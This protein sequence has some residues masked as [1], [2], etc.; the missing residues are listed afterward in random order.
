M[1]RKQTAT[2]KPKGLCPNMT[3]YLLGTFALAILAC[4]QSKDPD[5]ENFLSESSEPS[6]NTPFAPD[7]DH[8]PSE[9]AYAL[10]ETLQSLLR[11]QHQEP[12][13]PPS[14]VRL[15][16][17][18]I[19]AHIG[20]RCAQIQRD[21]ALDPGTFDSTSWLTLIDFLYRPAPATT[22]GRL[23]TAREA[24][25]R[26]LRHAVG[27]ADHRQSA[28]ELL[29]LLN[30][31]TAASHD[32]RERQRIRLQ[33]QGASSPH[34]Q[35]LQDALLAAEIL[36]AL[37][38]LATLPPNEKPEAFIEASLSS[39]PLAA[40]S[41]Q[42]NEDA[43]Q[44][45]RI[46]T[47]HCPT[48]CQ[49]DGA[50]GPVAQMPAPMPSPACPEQ[51]SLDPTISIANALVLLG[52]QHLQRFPAA[53]SGGRFPLLDNTWQNCLQQLSIPALLPLDASGRLWPGAPLIPSSPGKL[54]PVDPVHWLVT[55]THQNLT[56]RPWPHFTLGHTSVHTP[57]SLTLPAP[58]QWQ[59]QST[60]WQH[61][62]GQLLALLNAE[63][64]A[65]RTP[66]TLAI[67]AE[68][69][70]PYDALH[71]ALALLSEAGFESAA[72]LVDS[73]SPHG[74]APFVQPRAATLSLASPPPHTS[75]L[76]L[77]NQN[78]TIVTQRHRRIE[79][80]IAAI[81]P[82]LPD[83]YLAILRLHRHNPALQDLILDLPGDLPYEIVTRVVEALSYQRSGDITESTEHLLSAPIIFTASGAALPL[84]G[85]L[86]ISH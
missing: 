50:L 7:L 27:S 23:A 25:Y 39:C 36:P 61:A 20:I 6:T 54:P 15:A 24:I 3:P 55:L 72:L 8:L 71:S 1:S 21:H 60:E 48:F 59:R 12:L 30:I 82:F 40:L 26:D 28:L 29:P 64:R 37:L 11:R 86:F 69:N 2:I 81:S 80:P 32:Q 63:A 67:A 16:E 31:V 83:I 78:A 41:P 4:G 18:V 84:I 17:A 5:A 79:V 62:R 38:D 58:N 10:L 52:L 34:R 22:Q 14:A 51:A 74:G 35:S 53:P 76:L 68:L 75:R 70:L 85:P 73:K 77:R 9:D 44:R 65:P 49:P 19:L 47:T 46:L 66:H 33:V 42:N 45:L 13:P 43:N 56:I 57:P